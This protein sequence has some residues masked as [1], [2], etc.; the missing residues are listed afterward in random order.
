MPCACKWSR[1]AQQKCERA[2]TA[3]GKHM[4][5]EPSQE[6]SGSEYHASNSDSDASIR[7]VG[8]S[9]E[10]EIDDEVEA[11]AEALQH[12]YAVF[13]PPHLCLKAKMGE[14]R[15]KVTNRPPRYIGNSWTTIWQKKTAQ[16]NAAKGCMTLDAFIVRKVCCQSQRSS[17]ESDYGQKWQR[18]PSSD[19]NVEEITGPV[20][21]LEPGTVASA[22]E[23]RESDPLEAALPLLTNDPTAARLDEASIEDA[24]EVLAQQEANTAAPHPDAPIEGAEEGLDRSA[25]DL[26]AAHPDAA[27][28]DAITQ[29]TDQLAAI[30]FDHL[31]RSLDLWSDGIGM[32]IDRNALEDELEVRD[33]DAVVRG[34]PHN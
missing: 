1:N 30:C 12:L 9:N 25:G 27:I 11:S 6:H 2:S 10:R 13:L 18:S 24:L 31:E 21:N 22:A 23:I 29:L 7:V 15:C 8:C 14:K 20:V 32:H 17:L 4:R 26:A 16:E 33:N 19:D 5:S 28:N 34:D 3:F